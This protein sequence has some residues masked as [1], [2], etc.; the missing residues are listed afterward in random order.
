M[1]SRERFR[2]HECEVLNSRPDFNALF[3]W[4]TDPVIRFLE[5]SLQT[6]RS[7]YAAR[8]AWPFRGLNQAQ[9]RL[10]KFVDIDLLSWRQR[11]IE[12]ARQKALSKFNRSRRYRKKYAWQT[13]FLFRRP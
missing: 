13:I 8:P 4:Q 5:A 2:C 11:R 10:Y 6:R 7:L 9:D 1:F 12:R 3:G